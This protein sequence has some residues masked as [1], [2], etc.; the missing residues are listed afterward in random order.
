VLPRANID[1]PLDRGV[2]A[3]EQPDAG[4]ASGDGGRRQVFGE[5][6]DQFGSSFSAPGDYV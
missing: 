4:G 3:Q 1:P 5:R 2:R 6:R